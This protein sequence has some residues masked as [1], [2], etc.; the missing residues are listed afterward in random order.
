MGYGLSNN[1]SDEKIIEELRLVLEV[2][3]LV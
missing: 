1:E 2:K 3:E